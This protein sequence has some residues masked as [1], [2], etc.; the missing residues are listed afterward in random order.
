MTS[1]GIIYSMI[2]D[3]IDHSMNYPNRQTIH[4]EVLSNGITVL[5]Y[6]RFASPSFVLE[7][8]IR[9]GALAEIRAMAGLANF[10]AVSLMHGTQTR[11]FDQI[12]DQLESVGGDLSFSGGFHTS[13]FSGQGLIEDIDFILDLS[14]DAL[15]NPSFPEEQIAQLQGQLL[16]GLQMR[17]NDTRSMASLTFDELI[18]GDHPYGRSELGYIE[19]INTLTPTDLAQFHRQNYGPTGMIIT[20]VGAIKTEDAIA[21]VNQT[22]GDWH[23]PQQPPAK[24]VADMPRPTQR[25]QIHTPMPDKQQADIRLGLPGPRR[26]APDY[27][28]ASLMNTIL[29]VFGMMGRIGQ[30]VREE[31]GLAYYAYSRLQGGLGPAPWCAVAGVAPPVVEQAIEAILDEI[32]RIQDEIVPADE[33]ADNKAYRIGSL[34]MGLETNGGL[35]DVIS[36]ME[37]YTLGLDYLISYPEKIDAISA[38]QVQQAAQEYLS[39]DHLGIAVAGPTD[40]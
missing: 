17:A 16:T 28:E 2:A 32:K 21:K 22:F 36:D 13:G 4:R 34:P 15:R 35:A 37:F 30:S 40:E 31:K 7:G 14:A 5:V 29:G 20:I 10:T 11:S 25:Q 19:T 8:V 1:N 39:S 18:Y 9:T 24:Q 23:N 26:S 27:L 12:Y 38:E 3:K 33:L 6:E